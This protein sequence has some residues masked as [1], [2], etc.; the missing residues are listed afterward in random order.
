M[1]IFQINPSMFRSRVT[2]PILSEQ[3]LFGSKVVHPRFLLLSLTFCRHQFPR[4][5]SRV[6]GLPAWLTPRKRSRPSPPPTCIAWRRAEQAMPPASP[7]QENTSGCSA[8]KSVVDDTHKFLVASNNNGTFDR[9]GRQY[10][11][12][13]HVSGSEQ[14]P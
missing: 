11:Q 8:L 10:Y 12:R 6:A 5:S 2:H 7:T 3:V 14:G 1:C 9:E 13:N 4:Q